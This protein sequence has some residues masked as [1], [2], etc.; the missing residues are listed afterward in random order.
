MTNYKLGDYRFSI[1]VH[2]LD[3]VQL[4]PAY[5]ILSESSIGE[6]VCNTSLFPLWVILYKLIKAAVVNQVTATVAPTCGCPNFK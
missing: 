3:S 6:L 5:L 2:G 4:V 1:D